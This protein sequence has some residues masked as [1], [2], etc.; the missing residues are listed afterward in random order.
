M[1]KN[2]SRP[3]DLK[4]LVYKLKYQSPD[5]PLSSLENLVGS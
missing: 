4:L 3:L 5:F 2:S 1:N